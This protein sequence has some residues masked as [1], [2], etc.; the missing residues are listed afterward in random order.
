MATSSASQARS[1]SAHLIEDH[2]DSTMGTDHHRSERL[3]ELSKKRSPLDISKLE[4][5]KP[6]LIAI[7]L[8]LFY[9]LFGVLLFHFSSMRLSIADAF[10]FSVTTATTVGYGDI[11]PMVVQNQ[12]YPDGTSYVYHP[13]VGMLMLT[14]AYIFGG[15]C[16][17]GASLGLLIQRALDV[18]ERT[19]GRLVWCSPLVGAALLFAVLVGGGAGCICALEGWSYAVGLYWAVVTLSTVGYG[20]L[21][22]VT[23][24]GRL[25]ATV[26]MLFGVGCTAKLFSEI[27]ALPLRVHRRKIEKLV[28]TQ[29][30]D[31][32]EEARELERL[33]CLLRERTESLCPS[34]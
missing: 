13:S 30:G 17:I 34:L 19:P 26:F 9:V 11:S 23:E 15:V 31:E 4:G 14:V 10:Y 18:L 29:Y 2:H 7:C 16:I 22:P 27:A 12:T 8:L 1:L 25:F 28:L 6:T 32:L 24:G 5:S 3:I 21:T 33:P 20:G